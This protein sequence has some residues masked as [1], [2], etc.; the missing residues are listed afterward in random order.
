M[1]NWHCQLAKFFAPHLLL[2]PHIDYKVEVHRRAGCSIAAQRGDT[3]LEAL[4][5][6]AV[7][8]SVVFGES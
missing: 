6:R 1:H 2:A 3:G 8:V 5:G 7:R 4:P